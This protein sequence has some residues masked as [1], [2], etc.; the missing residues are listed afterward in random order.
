ME[1]EGHWSGVDLHFKMFLSWECKNIH[2]FREK[3]IINPYVPILEY[4]GT[5]KIIEEEFIHRKI[6]FSGNLGRHVFI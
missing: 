4:P 1:A 6:G 5:N 2:D 3:M